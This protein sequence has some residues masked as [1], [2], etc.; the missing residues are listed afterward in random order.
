MYDKLEFECSN[1]IRHGRGDYQSPG[2]TVLQTEFVP[3]RIRW[4]GAKS[5]FALFETFQSCGDGTFLVS[6][7]KVPKRSRLRESDPS[8]AGGGGSEVSAGQ[9]SIKSSILRDAMIL[10]GTA[11]GKR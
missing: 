8:A 11:T 6:A 5:K 10:S 7:R 9:R 4:A 1:F 3:R 2:G